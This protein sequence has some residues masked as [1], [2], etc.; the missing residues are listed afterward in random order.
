MGT[1]R[2]WRRAMSD[3]LSSGAVVTE[4]RLIHGM[5]SRGNS[6]PA[7]TFIRDSGRKRRAQRPHAVRVQGLSIKCVMR[8]P[9]VTDPEAS[10]DHGLSSVTLDAVARTL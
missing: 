10:V 6:A 8:S 7:S 9:V 4:Q 3:D 5:V 2:R 1:V